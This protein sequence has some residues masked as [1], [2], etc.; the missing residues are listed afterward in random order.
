MSKEE[1]GSPEQVHCNSKGHTNLSM[2]EG[3]GEIGE[4]RGTLTRRVEGREQENEEGDTTDVS[5]TRARD[6]EAETNQPRGPGL[7][8]KVDSSRARRP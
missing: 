8:G 4:R 7:A 2:R 1:D 6:V 5:G 3:L